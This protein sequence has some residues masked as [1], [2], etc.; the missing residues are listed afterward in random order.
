[1]RALFSANSRP[2][3]LSASRPYR[4]SGLGGPLPLARSPH[5]ENRRERLLR[6]LDHVGDVLFTL[7]AFVIAVF[8]KGYLLG[9]VGGGSQLLVVAALIAV[10]WY[11]S[12][13]L[14]GTHEPRPTD[15]FADA[16]VKLIKGVA[17]S[18]AVLLSFLYLFKLAE[19]MSRS[20]MGLFFVADVGLLVGRRLA[21]RGL[22]RRRVTDKSHRRNILIVGR[23]W[24]VKDAV[25]AIERIVHPAYRV[26]GCLDVDDSLRGNEVCPGVKMLGSMQRFAE[27]L[28]TE[29]VDEVV[30]IAPL[31]RIPG[32]AQHIEFAEQI[33]VVLRF[34]PNWGLDDVLTVPRVARA[35]Y[36]SFL[37]KPVL[38][39][40]SS[41]TD[42]PGIVLKHLLDRV[43]AV[44]GLLV[45]L[46]VMLG[47][48]LAIKLTSPGPVYF[49]QQRLGMNGRRFPMYKFRTMVRDAEGQR[50]ALHK[51]NEMDGPVFKLACDPRVTPI[52][53]LLRKTSLD[54]LPQLFNILRGEMSFVGPRPPLPGEVEQYEVWQR[55][56]LSMR[57]GLTCLWQV[58]GRNQIGFTDWMKMDLHYIDNWS[59]SMDF[60]LL[61]KTIAVVLKATGENT[62]ARRAPS[63]AAPAVAVDGPTAA[64]VESVDR[65]GA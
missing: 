45:C 46:P 21:R 55:R 27:I 18:M 51:D 57:P 37:G 34:L 63:V 61:L 10:I 24:R 17:L 29:S 22:W 7:V 47:I 26:V 53:R 65:A 9:G 48:A 38:T 44:A 39:L 41:P 64:T 43:L 62:G 1:M 35:S 31:G 52:G 5:L 15:I 14:A 40:S 36:E 49:R 30:F 58:G 54:E 60:M 50:A 19:L 4:P 13:D 59:L 23:R 42:H 32:A 11:V 28:M 20:M 6:R 12:L 3:P 33:G 8:V 2:R 56:R 25:Q 16:S